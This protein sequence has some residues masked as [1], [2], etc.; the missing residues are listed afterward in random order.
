MSESLDLVRL[1]YVH[2]ERGESSVAKWADPAIEWV[3][4]DGRDAGMRV[5]DLGL[6]E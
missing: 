2:V 6:E 4:A 3:N 1:I 5:V